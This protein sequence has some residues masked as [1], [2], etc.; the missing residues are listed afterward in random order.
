MEKG[1]KTAKAKIAKALVP[2]SADPKS[3]ELVL[4][5]MQLVE[6]EGMSLRQEAATVNQVG[7]LLV[8]LPLKV[9]IHR[10][11]GYVFVCDGIKNSAQT[12]IQ[13]PVVSTSSSSALSALLA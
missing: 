6:S 13:P 7:T 1:L 12:I 10:R 4:V 3:L 5:R 2:D 8:A 9:G 11:G